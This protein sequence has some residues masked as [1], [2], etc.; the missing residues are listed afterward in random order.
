VDDG[1]VNE[2]HA[3][4]I[5]AARIHGRAASGHGT[6]ALAERTKLSSQ[7]V[8]INPPMHF[9]RDLVLLSDGLQCYTQSSPELSAILLRQGRAGE[10]AKTQRPCVCMP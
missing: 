8:L 3:G 6:L 2:S 10:I 9:F 4:R 5:V 7:G 1:A